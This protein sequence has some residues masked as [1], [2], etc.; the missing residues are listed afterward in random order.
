MPA[1]VDSFLKT[2]LRSGLLDREQLQSALRA[3]PKERRDDPAGLADHLIKAGKLSRFQAHK[4]L[5][6]ATIGLMLGPYQVQTP[7]GKGGMG[8]VYLAVDTRSGQRVAPKV[9]PPKRALEEGRY[10]ARFL[11]EMELSRKVRHPHLALT[12]EA[13]ESQG[14][15]YIVLEYIPGLSLYRLVSR[16]GPLPIPRLARL[17][18]EVANALDY[19]HR[20]GLIHRDLKP[21]NILI[22]PN[23]HAKVL[24]L[25]LALMTGEETSDPEVV[26]GQGYVRSEEHTSELQS[27]ENLVCRLL[28]EKK[29]KK[30]NR[31]IIKTIIKSTD[32]QRHSRIQNS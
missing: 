1:T 12:Y 29:K 22:T 24:D 9:L 15:H 20:L 3:L 31:Y 16:E 7:I 30:Q 8:V 17:F 2:V 27:R 18:A 32:V 4:L 11:R 13:G 26:G 28:L 10:L 6:G 14:V 23:D 25:G 5:N 19:A 21:S